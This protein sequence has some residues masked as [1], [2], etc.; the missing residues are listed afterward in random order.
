MMTQTALY[1]PPSRHCYYTS[2]FTLNDRNKSPEKLKKKKKL[3][4][5]PLTATDPPIV[6]TYAQSFSLASFHELRIN[7]SF[8]T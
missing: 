2:R 8:S 6:S 1:F 3:G 5:V 4:S 7:D